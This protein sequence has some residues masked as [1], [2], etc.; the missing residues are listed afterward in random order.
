M[1][2]KNT[3]FTQYELTE[4]ETIIGT[5]LSNEQMAVLQNDLAEIAI[6]RA[7][8]RFDVKDDELRAKLLEDAALK[9]QITFIQYLLNRA[10]A[11]RQ[12]TQ[13]TQL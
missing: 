9:G 2:P 1:N 11:A 7:S 13:N 8:V 3:I 10:E 5:L 12:Q 4:E 6:R